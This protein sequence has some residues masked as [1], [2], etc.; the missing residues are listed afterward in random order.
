MTMTNVTSV[1]KDKA[2]LLSTDGS[3]VSRLLSIIIVIHYCR[4]V[5]DRMEVNSEKYHLK[6]QYNLQAYRKV[7]CKRT[8]YELSLMSKECVLH[9]KQ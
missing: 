6:E 8:S 4:S 9:S 1:K 7:N 5:L 3:I 2:V